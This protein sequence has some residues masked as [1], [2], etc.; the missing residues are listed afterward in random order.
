MSAAYFAEAARRMSGTAGALLG[1]SPDI[2]WRATPAELEAIVDALAPGDATMPP[3]RSTI[4]RL[5]EEHPDE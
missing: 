5:M 4:V 1:W 3:D 2:F